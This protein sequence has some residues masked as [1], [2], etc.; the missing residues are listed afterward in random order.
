MTN[1]HISLDKGQTERCKSSQTNAAQRGADADTC[2][3][4][5]FIMLPLLISLLA[6]PQTSN[7]SLS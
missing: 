1:V 3:C 6:S 4:W 7:L 5:G 2:S